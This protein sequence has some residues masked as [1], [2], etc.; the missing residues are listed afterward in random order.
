MKKAVWGAGIRVAAVDRPDTRV[1]CRVDPSRT[2]GTASSYL[3]IKESSAASGAD[4]G[5]FGSTLFSDV[6]TIIKDGETFRRSSPINGAREFRTRAQRSRGAD[7]AEFAGAEQLDHVDRYHVQ[8]IRADGRNTPGVDVPYPFDGAITV[9]V[10]GR[11]RPTRFE[12]VRHACEAGSALSGARRDSRHH[13]RRS[14][15]VTFYGHDQTGRAVSATAKIG[16][17][18]GN[19]ADPK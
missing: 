16:I 8:Y 15:R 17:E 13:H 12:I 7:V 18:F 2:Q 9:T 1:R 4:P 14:R 3:I 11:R 5:K 19:F 10:I 6:I